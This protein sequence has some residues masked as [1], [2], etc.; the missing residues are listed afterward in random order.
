MKTN[1]HIKYIISG[2]ILITCFTIARA[3]V[4]GFL[5]KTFTLTAGNHV[6]YSLG[7]PAKV[8]STNAGI[9]KRFFL[10]ADYVVGRKWTMGI[11]YQRLNTALLL[12]FDN[13]VENA[14]RAEEYTYALKAN[15]FKFSFTRFGSKSNFIA[16]VGRYFTVGLLMI[17]YTI[18]DEK[19]YMFTAGRDL[20][21]GHNIGVS[22]DVGKRRVFYKQLVVD[23]G[24]QAA[25]VLPKGGSE[26]ALQNEL[27]KG[28]A[29]RLLTAHLV[30]FKLGLG[31]LVL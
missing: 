31:W 24:I 20:F 22:F 3:Q 26:S 8:G 11:E 1:N 23:Y 5:G 4:P 19:G 16:P 2:F 30:T 13:T 15:T 29:D 28:G 17:N 9:D 27:A 14:T 21:E 18:S 7:A 10:G 6:G 12:S 25:L